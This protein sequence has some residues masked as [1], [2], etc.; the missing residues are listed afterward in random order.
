[1]T[2]NTQGA[3]DL[4]AALTEARDWFESQAKVVSKGY[5]ASEITHVMP[6]KP[7]TLPATRKQGEKQ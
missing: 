6:Y 1:M 5:G 3:A 2:T 7:P 4:I